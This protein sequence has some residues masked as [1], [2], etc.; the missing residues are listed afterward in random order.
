MFKKTILPIVLFVSLLTV[1]ACQS[2]PNIASTFMATPTPTA[3]PT[4]TPAPTTVPRARSPQSPNLGNIGGA[5]RLGDLSAGVV[6][7][8]KN[9]TLTLRGGKNSRVQTNSNT[10]V[11]MPDKLQGASVADIHTGDRVI[12]DYGANKDTTAALLLD[13]PA[14]YNAGNVMLGAV[15]TTKGT[16][17]NVRARTGN[18]RIAT[19]EQTLF[20]N[21]SGDQPAVGAF[22]DLKQGNVIAAIGQSGSDAF[23]AQIVVITDRDARALVNRGRNNQPRPTPTPKP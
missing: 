19:S 9:G 1:T 4:A 3:A 17:I 2:L 7:D 13:L 5:L 23:N 16:T 8:N 20:I 10:L 12:V 14:G 11:F 22:K 15:L 21:L 18:D 6:A